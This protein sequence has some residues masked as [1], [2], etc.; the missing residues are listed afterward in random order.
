MQGLAVAAKITKADVDKLPQ[1]PLLREILS[2]DQPMTEWR[3][4][5]RVMID[6]DTKLF[7][8]KAS[9]LGIHSGKLSADNAARKHQMVLKDIALAALA[10][11]TDKLSGQDGTGASRT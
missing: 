7:E 2:G 5:H 10:I 4:A 8:V 11:L 3:A 1:L 6:E 9:P